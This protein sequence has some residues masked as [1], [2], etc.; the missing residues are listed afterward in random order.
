MFI[1]SRRPSRRMLSRVATAGRVSRGHPAA[2]GGGEPRRARVTEL[3]DEDGE[4]ERQVGVRSAAT[5]AD[6]DQ[7]NGLE[8]L[9][10]IPGRRLVPFVEIAKHLLADSNRKEAAPF[11][12]QRLGNP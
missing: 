3:G 8:G 5:A 2:G 7:R 10:Q 12:L 4:G 1:G 11:P 9:R 6:G